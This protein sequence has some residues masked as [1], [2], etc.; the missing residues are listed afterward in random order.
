VA[1]GRLPPPGPISADQRS[2]IEAAGAGPRAAPGA[3]RAVVPLS[4]A[5][6]P[7]KAV[8][9][10]LRPFW[11]GFSYSVGVLFAG[12]RAILGITSARNEDTAAARAQLSALS[13][14]TGPPFSH[15]DRVVSFRC[16]CAPWRS[17]WELFPRRTVSRV[18]AAR[19]REKPSVTD[20]RYRFRAA[21][22]AISSFHPVSRFPRPSP[23]SKSPGVP[24]FR[25]PR[26]LA[27]SATLADFHGQRPALKPTISLVTC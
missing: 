7:Q 23:P 25:L 10:H 15:P 22:G 4:R 13:P 9:G 6:P 3:S 16:Q 19:Y 20:V 24:N 26:R 8:L 14:A 17:P 2:H 1:Q 5:R 21:G 18:T 27:M 11:S 12:K